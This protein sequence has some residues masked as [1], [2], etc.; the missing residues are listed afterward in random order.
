MRAPHVGRLTG[1]VGGTSPGFIE[2]CATDKISENCGQIRTTDKLREKTANLHAPGQ[3]PPT[4]RYYRVV[5][6]NHSSQPQQHSRP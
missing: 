4:D 6:S 1:R 2:C 5:D 3:A